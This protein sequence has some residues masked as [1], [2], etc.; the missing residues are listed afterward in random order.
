[1]IE[2]YTHCL[3]F[4]INMRMQACNQLQ[5]SDRQIVSTDIYLDQKP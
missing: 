2:K 3:W 1:M 4:Y 5:G